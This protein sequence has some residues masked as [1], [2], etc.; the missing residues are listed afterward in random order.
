MDTNK[1]DGSKNINCFIFVL[2]EVDV[3]QCIHI[4]EAEPSHW[5]SV[6][7]FNVFT[8]FLEASDNSYCHNICAA[9]LMI[10]CDS[11]RHDCQNTDL[12][13]ETHLSC[14]QTLIWRRSGKT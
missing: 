1:Q 12:V 14:H 4:S 8:F 10:D 9:L 5:S 7:Q 2:S 11:C 3:L 13:W 6:E